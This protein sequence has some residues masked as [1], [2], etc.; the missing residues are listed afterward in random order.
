MSLRQRSTFTSHVRSSTRACRRPESSAHWQAHV[1]KIFHEKLN[2]IE[3][4]D[5]PSP[6]HFGQALLMSV[7]VGDLTLSG[8]K[9]KHGE[10]WRALSEYVNLDPPNE[11]G[12]VLGRNHRLVWMDGKK[13]LALESSFFAKQRVQLCGEQA[14]QELCIS[15]LG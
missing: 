8:V 14:N 4:P 10:F 7:Y 15:L 11:F 12:R 1:S 2:G 9:S 13:T 3:F 6:F 5:M